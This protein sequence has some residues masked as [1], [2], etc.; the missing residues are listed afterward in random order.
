MSSFEQSEWR[1]T[2]CRHQSLCEAR[3]PRLKASMAEC[4]AAYPLPR[5]RQYKP[6]P[7]WQTAILPSTGENIGK[8][9]QRRQ[10]ATQSKVP[11]IGHIQAA[12]VF[13]SDRSIPPKSSTCTGRVSCDHPCRL[14]R[15]AMKATSAPRRTRRPIAAKKPS[16]MPR[17]LVLEP[18]SPGKA[19]PA[20]TPSWT[21]S[22]ER[23]SMGK[24]SAR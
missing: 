13:A 16:V 20:H 22:C 8:C 15:E 4:W 6:V 3:S 1:R 11:Q 2:A 10:V 18:R 9:D 21:V 17:L 7:P 23:P 19:Y 14:H 12:P 5:A 24:E